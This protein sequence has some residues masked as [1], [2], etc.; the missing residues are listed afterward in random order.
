MEDDPPLAGALASDANSAGVA[1]EL[2]TNDAAMEGYQVEDSHKIAQSKILE[3]DPNNPAEVV[4]VGKWST[5]NALN[6]AIGGNKLAT[7]EGSI[8]HDPRRR[9]EGQP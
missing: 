2:A 4:L 6:R 1:E 3:Q 5:I 8:F 9:P 7:G